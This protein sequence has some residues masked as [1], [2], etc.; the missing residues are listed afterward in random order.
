MVYHCSTLVAEE[1]GISVWST[2]R[3]VVQRNG[4]WVS[5]HCFEN[6]SLIR[7]FTATHRLASLVLGGGCPPGRRSYTMTSSTKPDQPWP[8]RGRP[9]GVCAQPPVPST[10]SDQPRAPW[11]L[12][13]TFPE[14]PGR[15][16][17]ASWEEKA[18]REGEDLLPTS[19]SA[20]NKSALEEY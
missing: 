11:L 13:A 10:Q 6:C 20:C 17:D 9:S 7:E 2:G 8:W 3:A 16:P 5:L 15:D 19:P 14:T 4:F 1:G 12:A 18:M